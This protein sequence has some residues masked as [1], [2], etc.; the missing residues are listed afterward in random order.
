MGLVVCRLNLHLDNTDWDDSSPRRLLEGCRDTRAHTF[1]PPGRC[2]SS[3]RI[4]PALGYL[5]TLFRDHGPEVEEDLVCH[6]GK[7]QDAGRKPRSILYQVTGPN[8]Q[9]P[10]L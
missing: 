6:G 3:R 1:R 7:T 4:A 5:L 9:L 2:P 10:V 8:S